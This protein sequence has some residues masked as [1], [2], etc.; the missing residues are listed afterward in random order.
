[1]DS[2]WTPRA[3]MKT[4]RFSLNLSSTASNLII[5]V[6]VRKK[7]KL[8]VVKNQCAVYKVNI[9]NLCDAGYVWRHLQECISE[10]KYS[11]IDRHIEEHGLTKSAVQDNQFSILM[12]CR[13][14][15][16]CLLFEKLVINE[17]NTEKN[18]ISLF[19]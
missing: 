17:L 3:N 7:N 12:K 1:M 14:R 5:K 18:S 8:P 11:A 19:T 13:S 9:R 15:R 2:A 10:H 16:D 4:R 6:L